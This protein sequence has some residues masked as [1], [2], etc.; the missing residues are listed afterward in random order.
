MVATIDP[1]SLTA[2]KSILVL[3]WH[4]VFANQAFHLHTRI[5]HR[6]LHYQ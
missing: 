2:S 3:N 5:G 4:P 6:E 1:S